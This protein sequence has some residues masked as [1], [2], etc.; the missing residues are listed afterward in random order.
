MK[1]TTKDRIINWARWAC[2]GTRRGNGTMTGYI[3]DRMRIAAQGEAGSLSG[4]G[5]RIDSADAALVERA[6]KRLQ[7]LRRELLRWH[8]IQDARP[9]LTCR[10]LGLKPRPT[11]IYDIELAK[12]EAELGQVLALQA[13]EGSPSRTSTRAYAHGA[14]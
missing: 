2:G 9:E 10:C 12:A 7:P 11:S 3:C 13:D 14:A 8:Y 1:Q 6:W 5:D 4:F